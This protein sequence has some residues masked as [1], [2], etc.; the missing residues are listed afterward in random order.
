M[1][2]GPRYLLR[3]FG[4]D[5][6]DVLVSAQMLFHYHMNM[7]G[8]PRSKACGDDGGFLVRG[9]RISVINTVVPESAGHLS[10]IS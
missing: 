9:E 10:G 6:K 2:G 4:D 1:Q 5:V 7:Q 3:K 8:D